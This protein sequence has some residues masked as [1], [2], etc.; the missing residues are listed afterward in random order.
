MLEVLS[1]SQM[2]AADRAAIKLG[3]RGISGETL[4]EA[5]GSQVARAILE[6]FGVQPTAILCG[7]G[8]NGGDGFVIA[9]H[10]KQ[11]GVK[12]KVALLGEKTKLRGDAVLFVWDNCGV[13][14]CYSQWM[15][16]QSSHGKPVCQCTNHRCLG[17]GFN[18]SQPDELTMKHPAGDE[19][20]EHQDEQSC[21]EAFH[22]HELF[23]S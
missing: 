7:P 20:Q 9:R 23:G 22:L 21:R 16:K 13:G 18:E 1:V 5:A 6:Q 15:T 4:M 19:N 2:Y 14:D 12:V 8:N 10:L 17:G 11:A 3:K